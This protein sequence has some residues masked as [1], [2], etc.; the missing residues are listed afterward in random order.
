MTHST[1]PRTDD[2]RSRRLLSASFDVMMQVPVW[3]SSVRHLPFLVGPPRAYLI[4]S[5][6]TH[7]ALPYSSSVASYHPIYIYLP[8][9]RLFV[10]DLPVST[11]VPAVRH[12]PGASCIFLGDWPRVLRPPTTATP[13][14][15]AAPFFHASR[16]SAPLSQGSFRAFYRTRAPTPV[17]RR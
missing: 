17:P 10:H 9:L 16:A 12:S 14:V 7:R 3:V 4:D 6:V 11:A 13:P 5:Y 2:I 8:S 1:T 15:P